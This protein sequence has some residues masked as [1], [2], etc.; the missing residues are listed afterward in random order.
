MTETEYPNPVQRFWYEKLRWCG[1][2]NPEDALAFMRD[3]MQVMK[4]GSDGNRSELGVPYEQSAWAKRAK[5]LEE[6]LP[7]PLGLSYLYMLDH[8]G[9]T[10]HG[11]SVGGS[12]LSEEGEKALELLK[13]GD[14]E[15]AMDMEFA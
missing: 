8:L 6:M 10:E 3:I 14:L 7:G 12:W 13:A 2:G 9:L 1:C 5:Q 15:E 4:D 11:G